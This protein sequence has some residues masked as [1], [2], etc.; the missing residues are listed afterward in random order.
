MAHP[1]ACSAACASPA[2][3]GG[4]GEIAPEQLG[5]RL[6]RGRAAAVASRAVGPAKPPGSG[7][8]RGGETLLESRSVCPNAGRHFQRIC[9]NVF[10]FCDGWKGCL[11][12]QGLPAPAPI[13]CGGARHAPAGSR[14]PG[15]LA[16]GGPACSG[17]RGARSLSAEPGEEFH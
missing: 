8:E 2:G 14:G 5:A 17:V 12:G 15:E 16:S 13:P 11:G 1:M 3:A 10:A 9:L 7:E 6:P 4:R